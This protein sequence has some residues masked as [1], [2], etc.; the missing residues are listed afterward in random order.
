[1]IK[2]FLQNND[3]TS[4]RLTVVVAVATPSVVFG[5]VRVTVETAAPPNVT[6]TESVAAVE[7][8]VY[9]NVTVSDA[10][11]VPASVYVN[12]TF[13]SASDSLEVAA[14]VLR[15]ATV[16]VTAAFAIAFEKRSVTLAER[17]TVPLATAAIGPAGVAVT[18][19]VPAKA[20]PASVVTT[21]AVAPIPITVVD[22]VGVVTEY[23]PVPRTPCVVDT[24]HDNAAA[25]IEQTCW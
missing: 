20:E 3:V 11:I 6:V 2:K 9:E 13:P 15:P 25:A 21:A 17:V 23:E 10:V 14:T 24:E 19:F 1:M 18:V 22:T 12:V 5:V 7:T 4:I 8:A 16:T